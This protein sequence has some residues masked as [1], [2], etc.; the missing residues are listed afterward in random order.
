MRARNA[1]VGGVWSTSGGAAACNIQRSEIDHI[2]RGS[3]H[4]RG[5]NLCLVIYR[6]RNTASALPNN[7]IFD[8]KVP[9]VVLAVLLPNR[10][11]FLFKIY[12]FN[13]FD[14]DC[15]LPSNKANNND[16]KANFH[17]FCDFGLSPHNKF[18]AFSFV[19]LDRL[20]LYCAQ[21]SV[22]VV[23]A[24]NARSQ[25]SQGAKTLSHCRVRMLRVHSTGNSHTEYTFRTSALARTSCSIIQ[26]D[27]VEYAPIQVTLVLFSSCKNYI[28][29]QVW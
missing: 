17:I 7:I 4:F 25:H 1:I 27:C 22:L 18:R 10:K 21:V 12:R 11:Y 23:A 13:M 15:L 14:V 26:T 28:A 6:F 19:Y 3:F 20:P 5:A 8:Q 2:C 16:V 9:P 24:V 29:V